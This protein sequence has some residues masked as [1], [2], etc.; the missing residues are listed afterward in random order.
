MAPR[1]GVSS[2][3][4]VHVTCAH[5][6][7][8]LLER[9]VHARSEDELDQHALRGRKHRVQLEEQREEIK[10]VNYYQRPGEKGDTT[11]NNRPDLELDRGWD[12]GWREEARDEH[13]YEC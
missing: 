13:E 5:F 8:R 3:G 9:G 2:G 4:R 11:V 1:V 6:Q 12:V 10:E 7:N